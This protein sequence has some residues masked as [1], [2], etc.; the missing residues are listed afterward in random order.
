MMM[1]QLLPFLLEKD[2]NDTTIIGQADCDRGLGVFGGQVFEDV[3]A[4][5]AGSLLLSC[6][7]QAEGC[8][9]YGYC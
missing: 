6:C 9:K 4:F 3:A 7:G 5:C 2:L 8:Y 1:V